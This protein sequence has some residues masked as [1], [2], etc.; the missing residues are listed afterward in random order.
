MGK[1]IVIEFISLD[2]VIQDPDGSAGTPGGGWAFR[3]GPEAVAGDKFQLGQV[4]DTGVMLLGRLTW[5]RFSRIWPSRVDAFSRQMNAIPKLVA[6]R[7]LEH[8]E[9]WDN[10]ALLQGDLV[11]EVAKLK[12]ARDVVV[13]GS[14]AVVDALKAHDLVDQYRLLV[15]PTVLGRGRRL[16]DEP[17][18]PIDLELVTAEGVG[19]AVLLVYNRMPT[20]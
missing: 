4:L 16:F 2:G 10:S 8:L 20:K 3:Y 18:Q 19:Q 12:L 9:E 15:F 7:S 14:V 1:V 17:G 5:Q 13:T 11:D 6:S